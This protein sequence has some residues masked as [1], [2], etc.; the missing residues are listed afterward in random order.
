MTTF[1]DKRTFKTSN[2]EAALINIIIIIIKYT[3]TSRIL[4][5]HEE[6]L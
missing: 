1:V 5:E 2:L 3:M 6:E 4:S